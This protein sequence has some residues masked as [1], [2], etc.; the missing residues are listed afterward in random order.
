MIL[1]SLCIISGLMGFLIST[2]LF[3]NKKSNPI[4]NTYLVLLISIIS[5][6]FFIFGLFNSFS[7]HTLLNIYS[8]YCNITLVIIPLCY[9]YFKNLDPSYSSRIKDLFHLI[10]PIAYFFVTLQIY[11]YTKP[12][13][14]KRFI[15]YFFLIIFLISYIIWSYKVLKSKVW[16]RKKNSKIL[17]NWTLF[18]LIGLI[19]ISIRLLASIFTEIQ[20]NEIS[21]GFKHQ[22]IS[23]VI[24]S[25]IVIKMLVTPEI[26]YGY[27]IMHQKLKENRS[28]NLI[29]NEIWNINPI[30]AINN[31]QH[32]T[33]KEK[34]EQHITD[35]FELIEKNTSQKKYFRDS[36]VSLSDF[37]TKL[38]IPKSHLAYLF[39]YH[40]KI[41][42]SEY[43][44]LIQIQDAILLIKDGYLK[45]NTMDSLSK[46]VGFTSYNPFFTSFKNIMGVAPLEYI[47]Q[48]NSVAI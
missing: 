23:A 32:L 11:N 1:N 43:K 38:N 45:N 44:K 22:W 9:L 42:F 7:N 2:I 3:V 12:D 35:Y 6:R 16:N 36:K 41:S 40:C 30:V 5:C 34:M 19:L 26:L 15:L 18:L 14:Y 39:K 33:L 8:Q 27:N 21:R 20:T 47:N 4:I 10:F 37:A 17:T 29:L 48:I 46:E 31:S 28:S 13:I 24:W 25:I